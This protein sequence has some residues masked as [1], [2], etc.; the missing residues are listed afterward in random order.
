MLPLSVDLAALSSLRPPAKPAIEPGER[1]GGDPGS[2]RS[3]IPFPAVTVDFALQRPCTH[4]A[5]RGGHAAPAWVGAWVLATGLA[6]S[7]IRRR[8][9]LWAA[10]EL[11]ARRARAP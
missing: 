7:E 6:G 2:L 1:W 11:M 9:L 8:H 3:V 10:K 4:P 5:L